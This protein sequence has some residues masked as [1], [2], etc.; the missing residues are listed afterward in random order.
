MSEEEKDVQEPHDD[1]EVTDEADEANSDTIAAKEEVNRITNE[2]VSYLASKGYD[3]FT[4]FL[5]PRGFFEV[6]LQQYL[7]IAEAMDIDLGKCIFVWQDDHHK[8]WVGYSSETKRIIS[9]F[10]S[11]DL[12]Q[13][14]LT[15]REHMAN[16]LLDRANFENANGNVDFGRMIAEMTQEFLSGTI[17]LDD[18]LPEQAREEEAKGKHEE[19]VLEDV[20]SDGDGHVGPGDAGLPGEGIQ[21]PGSGDG[22]SDGDG[23]PGVVL[24]EGTDG[25]DSCP[26]H[27]GVHS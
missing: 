26:P 19:G 6:S 24:D 12:I 21:K 3:N 20:V 23:D 15:Y 5:Y 9:L 11:K 18:H 10:T 17:T 4:G 14:M 22:S 7:N 8:R 27:D 13:T 16:W 25:G 2:L 1:V